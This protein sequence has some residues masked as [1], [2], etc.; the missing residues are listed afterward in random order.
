MRKNGEKLD[1]LNM[2]LAIRE[3]ELQE[4]EQE[5]KAEMQMAFSSRK[6]QEAEALIKF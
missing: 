6:L 1:E 3:S 5:L 2:Q 4:R